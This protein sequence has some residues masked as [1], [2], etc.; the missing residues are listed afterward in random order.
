M[1]K[2][3]HEANSVNWEDGR[4]Q[5]AIDH[6]ARQR[7]DDGISR[8]ELVFW[9]LGTDYGATYIT[10]DFKVK[11]SKTRRARVIAMAH[12]HALSLLALNLSW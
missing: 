12:V 1:R 6:C 3:R 9:V 5:D 4:R 2:R 11:T 7:N 8:I 10:P